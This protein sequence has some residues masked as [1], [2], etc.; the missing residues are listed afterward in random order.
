MHDPNLKL[1]FCVK[2]IVVKG[3]V[4]QIFDRDPGLFFYQ[5]LKRIFNKKNKSYTFFDIKQKLRRKSE[6]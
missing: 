1:E 2:N 5:I 3:S 6:I 4:S